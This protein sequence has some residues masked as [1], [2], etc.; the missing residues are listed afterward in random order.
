MSRV[1]HFV[2]PYRYAAQIHQTEPPAKVTHKHVE[3]TN[4]VQIGERGYV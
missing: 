4:Q 1:D 2:L 3:I